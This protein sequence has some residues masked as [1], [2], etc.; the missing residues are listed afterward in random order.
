M[1]HVVL[2]VISVNQLGHYFKSN[3]IALLV[4][5]KFYTYFSSE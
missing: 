4:T 1:G 5:V 2:S 3:T